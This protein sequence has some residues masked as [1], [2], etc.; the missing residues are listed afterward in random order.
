MKTKERYCPFCNEKLFME[1]FISFTDYHHTMIDHYFSERLSF[2]K[3]SESNLIKDE[4]G[5]FVRNIIKIKLFLL[6]KSGEKYYLK[7]NFD[8]DNFQVWK[9]NSTVKRNTIQTTFQPDYS[10]RDA[11]LNKIKTYLIFS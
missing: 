1:S 11:L 3:D 9:K 6:D 8:D 7:V 10:N 5:D 2:V 4:N